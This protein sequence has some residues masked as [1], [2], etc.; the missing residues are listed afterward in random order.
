MLI[1]LTN[2][3]VEFFLA[4][5]VLLDKTD[6]SFKWSKRTGMEIRMRI[7]VSCR[8]TVQTQNCMKMFYIQD[9]NIHSNNVTR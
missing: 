4:A 3:P 5:P 7:S 8:L 2:E 9:N 1:G 6:E